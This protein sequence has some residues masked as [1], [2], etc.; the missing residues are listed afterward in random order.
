MN[1]PAMA[2]KTFEELKNQ[3]EYSSIINGIVDKLTK[4]LSPI[5]R[6]KLIHQEIENYNQEI[7]SHPLVK[8]FSPCKMGCSACCHT[9]VSVTDDEAELLVKRVKDG[10]DIDNER[11]IKQ[12]SAQDDSHAYFSLPYADRKCVFLDDH[13]SCRVYADRPAVCRTNAVLGTADQCDT[14]SSIKPT[15]LIRTPKSDMVIYASFLSSSTSGALP[16]L[17]GKKLNL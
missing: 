1:V 7:F 9:Q 12:M 10:V 3:I 2:K 15:R 6:A 4:I 14:S 16:N 13:G 17:V 11:L 5:D 8:E